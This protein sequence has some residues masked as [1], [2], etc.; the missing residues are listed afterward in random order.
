[1]RASR[2]VGRESQRASPFRYVP[3]SRVDPEAGRSGEETEL[4]GREARGPQ[5]H[6]GVSAR[7]VLHHGALVVD[8]ALGIDNAHL[9]LTIAAFAIAAVR[10]SAESI[11]TATS[12][13]ASGNASPRDSSTL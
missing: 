7:L 6:L 3:P 12:E 13:I 8:P 1:M 5:V 2:Q 10:A 4:S 11:T 9:V